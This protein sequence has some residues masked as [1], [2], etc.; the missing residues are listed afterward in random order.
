MTRNNYN[1]EIGIVVLATVLAFGAFTFSAHA[2]SVGVY[3]TTSANTSGGVNVHTS[4][5]IKTDTQSQKIITRSDTAIAARITALNDLSTR[6]SALKN[7]SAT[8][9]ASIAADVQANIAGLT[10]LKAKID[11]E[12][13]VATLQTD[14]KSILGSFRIY[15]LVIPQGYIASSADRVDTI[16]GMLTT[17]SAKLQ[18]RITT[19]QNAGKNVSAEVSL[20]ADLNAKIADANTNAST[21]ATAIA[22][23]MPDQGNATVAASNKAT[24]VSARANLKTATSDLKTAR[25]DANTI[26]KDIQALHVNVTSS[27]SATVQ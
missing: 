4:A 15:A 16:T 20:L 19:A 23:L 21:A 12:S 8:E 13:D 3:N 24:L 11:G 5:T 18:T 25:D 9:K 22:N 17:I 10:S 1:K 6:V 2:A 26:I 27:S 7:V 14:E